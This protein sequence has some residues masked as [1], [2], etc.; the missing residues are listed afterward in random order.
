[1]NKYIWMYDRL[2]AMS[3]ME[4]GWRLNQKRINHLEKTKYTTKREK[5]TETVFNRDLTN[6]QIDSNRIYEEIYDNEKDVL[7]QPE[8]IGG[9]S[10]ESHK[11]A[12]NY[13][14]PLDHDRLSYNDATDEKNVWPDIIS[15]EIDYKGRDDIG[16]ARLNWEL[17]R[18]HQFVILA[19]NYYVA[20]DSK[21]IKEFN[22]LFDD[23]NNNNYFLWGISWTIPME[24]AIRCINWIYTYYYL[25]K[26]TSTESLKEQLR[27]GIIN[28]TDYLSRHYSK[29]S[30]ANNH[31]IVE[32]CAIGIAG[33]ICNY[34]KWEHLSS[35]ILNR[36]IEKQNF[37][38]GVNKEEALHYQA[39]GM[40]AI[41][42]YIGTL[43]KNKKQYPE[44][45]N[46][47]LI[48]MC[49]YLM[50]S[51]GDS[52][53]IIRF[54]DDDEGQILRINGT[55]S[56]YE[57]VLNIYKS[58]FKSSELDNYKSP[59]CAMYEDGGYSILRSK[60]HK[61]FMAFDYGPLGLN[62]IAAHGH[63]DALSFQMYF[64][65]T[66]IFSDPGTYIYHCNYEKRNLFRESF[67][68]NTVC[69]NDKCQSEIKGPFLWG[70]KAE[71]GLASS[72]IDAEEATITGFCEG[73]ASSK[74][75]RT[76][77]FNYDRK[78]EVI[79]EF[80][81]NGSKKINFIFSPEITVKIENSIVK[82]ENSKCVG[83]ISFTGDFKKI[84][85]ESRKYSEKYG[86]LEDTNAIVLTTNDTKIISTIGILENE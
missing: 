8:L 60:D 31:T 41:G 49:H 14:F 68:H 64:N 12:W 50:D 39:F 86:M 81:G 48:N 18:H 7:I 47:R 82:F 59:L 42:L 17:N 10:Y 30:S 22:Y 63:A 62:P 75:E 15:Y 56:Y 79:D 32:A 44:K 45:W 67:M 11:K 74:H 13:G 23:W 65:G 19:R 40:E 73:Y 71:S 3:I 36:E 58:L 51:I 55:K 66:E 26:C 16:D 2:K 9:F 21:Y 52:G 57:Y 43:L 5:V 33:T 37:E 25:D 24:I 27:I 38:D 28:M 34:Q 61:L 76:I 1:M 46:K 29:Y 53:E 69:I 54:G 77:R 84:E 70:R 80:D 78:V 6:L 85:L 20:N 72:S 35:D 83:T 4:I